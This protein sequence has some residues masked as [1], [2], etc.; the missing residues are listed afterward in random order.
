MNERLPTFEV[1]NK[2]GPDYKVV[3]VGDATMAPYE[4]THAGGSVEH[5]NEE[6]GLV[7][8]NRFRE[9]YERLVWLNPTPQET[10]E[11]SSSVA[12]TQE[13]VGG[14]MFPLTIRGIEESMSFLSK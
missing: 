8:M 6:P 1:L 2:F 12:M 5:W 9:T 3:F 14:N 11:Y 7:W 10:W 4:I 13:L